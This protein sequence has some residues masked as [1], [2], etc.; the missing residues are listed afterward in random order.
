MFLDFL[1][2][3]D[4][5]L[6]LLFL[7]RDQSPLMSF[8]MSSQESSR[9]SLSWFPP[10][11]TWKLKSNKKK[12]EEEEKQREETFLSC[13]VDDGGRKCV[14]CHEALYVSSWSH[15]IE[16]EA[17]FSK[18][19]FILLMTWL[20]TA[21][22][23]L[24]ETSTLFLFDSVPW[25]WLFLYRQLR[26]SRR[27][28]LCFLF[29]LLV[30]EDIVFSLLCFVWVMN[31][32]FVWRKSFSPEKRQRMQK[33]NREEEKEKKVNRF[34]FF[35]SSLF[36]PF[37]QCPKMT[38]KSLFLRL[39]LLTLWNGKE[40]S[41][42]REWRTDKLLF[43]SSRDSFSSV[44]L[45]SFPG[46]TRSICEDDFH[47]PHKILLVVHDSSFAYID[48]LL[49]F[50]TISHSRCHYQFLRQMEKIPF[51]GIKECL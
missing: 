23:S 41:G 30:V 8:L 48:I 28:T 24:E 3:F 29:T 19:P 16:E 11:Q 21:L 35:Y 42:R 36:S 44:F 43:R 12:E 2:S 9:K 20:D 45:S 27:R 14:R 51:P 46:D 17:F 37:S 25:E 18:Q 7:E 10:D 34:L 38:T 6:L 32:P 39:S 15:D 22:Y 1:L 40:G 47:C 50:T 49:D 13:F 4:I 26:R 5:L 31:I 33:S